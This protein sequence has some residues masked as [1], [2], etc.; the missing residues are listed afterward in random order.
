MQNRILNLG[1]VTGLDYRDPLIDP[2]A[3]FQKFKSHPFIAK[4]LEGGKMIRYGAKAIAAGGWN[5][6]P[7]MYCGRRPDRRRQRRLSECRAIEGNSL[8][9]QERHARRRDDLRSIV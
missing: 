4:L 3:E 7:K 1:Y 5:A 2:H 8:G 6:M 9:D